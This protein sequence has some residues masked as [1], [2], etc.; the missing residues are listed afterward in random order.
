VE[1]DKLG[2]DVVFLEYM[3]YCIT[4][5]VADV[6]NY[7]QRQVRERRDL[8]LLQISYFLIGVLS[9]LVAGLIGLVNQSVGVGILIVP[10]IVFT[11]LSLNIVAW[12]LIK[13]ALDTFLPPARGKKRK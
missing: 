11:A 5:M 7:I 9:L 12:A 10:L 13:L 1:W 2:V 6:V 3:W 8:K 4:I